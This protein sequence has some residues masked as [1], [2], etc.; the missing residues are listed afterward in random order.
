MGLLGKL[1]VVCSTAVVSPLVYFVVLGC[2]YH[3][4]WEMDRELER[5]DAAQW[6]EYFSSE[7]VSPRRASLRV[8]PLTQHIEEMNPLLEMPNMEAFGVD[9]PSGPDR[10]EGAGEGSDDEWLYVGDQADPYI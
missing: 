2:L 9:F 3:L 1:G 6:L 10:G 7:D 4:A 8:V 5:A